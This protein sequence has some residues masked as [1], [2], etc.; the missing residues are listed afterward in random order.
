MKRVAA[1]ALVLMF[2]VGCAGRGGTKTGSSL[3]RQVDDS[4][5]RDH[6]SDFSQRPIG[7]R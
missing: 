6:A 7:Q 4:S 5:Q 1:V 2:A 3:T